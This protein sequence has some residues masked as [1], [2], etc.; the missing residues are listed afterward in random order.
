[1]TLEEFLV[2]LARKSRRGRV[3]WRLYDG[4]LRSSEEFEHCPLSFVAGQYA[5]IDVCAWRLGLRLSTAVRIADAADH[6]G[7]TDGLRT[8]LVRATVGRE[9]TH[10]GNRR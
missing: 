5:A 3:A 2:K 7:S 4:R 6:A 10:L 9:T 8:R 1:M